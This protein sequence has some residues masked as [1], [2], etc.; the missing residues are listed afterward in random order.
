[1]G[2]AFPLVDVW[3]DVDAS[4][5]NGIINHPEVRPHVADSSL[6]EIDLSKQVENP[7]NFVLSGEYGA[8]LL[9]RI[10]PG[11]FEVHTQ[12]L[13]EA[14][15]DWAKHFVFAGTHWMFT[16][17]DAFEIVTR[18]PAGNAGA[19]ALALLAGMRKEFSGDH[20]MRYLDQDV[21]FDVYS[22]R[23]QDWAAHAP[24]LVETGHWLHHR[25]H[26]EERRLGLIEGTPEAEEATHGLKITPHADMAG[27]NRYVGLVYH[28]SRGGQLAKGV[29][30]YNRWALASH[31]PVDRLVKLI[32]TEPPVVRFDASDIE[33]LPDGD[34]R[35]SFVPGIMEAK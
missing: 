18:V 9:S 7:N 3:R 1:M 33:L 32:S 10:M 35:M 8:F 21:P 12:V 6:G 24:G 34:I 31:R 27:H 16:H 13:P 20:P 2:P 5:I 28:M 11:V 22:F 15:G 19:R 14:R 4:H 26:E 17:T 29:N 23:L 25:F 30:M